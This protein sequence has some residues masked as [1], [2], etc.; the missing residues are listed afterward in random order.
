M[1]TARKLQDNKISFIDLASQ[2]QAIRP[3][4]DA[5][6]ARVLAHGQYIMGPEVLELEHKLAQFCGA[7]HA[8]TCSSGTDALLLILMAKGIKAGDAVLVPSFT[9]TAT[10]EAISLLGAT[11]IFVDILADTFNM[12]AHS[13][14]KGIVKAK[15]LGLNPKAVIAVD[16]FGQAA[17][18]DA[19][20]AI[21]KKYGLWV[22][23][24]AAQS[25]GGSYRGRKIGTIGTATATSFFPAKPLGCYGDGGAVFTDNEQL[26]AIIRSKR[27]HGTGQDKYDS[28]RIGL[29]ARFDTIQAAILLEKL[30]LFPDEIKARQNIAARYNEALASKVT[31][32]QLGA[33]VTSVWAQYT[34]VLQRGQNRESVVNFMSAQ[35][36]P[37]AVY[38]SKP[39]H[40]QIAYKTHPTATTTLP[41]CEDLSTRV[42]S[43]PMHAY[44][45]ENTQDKII[46]TFLTAIQ[47]G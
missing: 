3:Q 17:D 20:E 23:D 38:Y 45:D 22:L 18:Y 37:T 27:V 21:A 16:L 35:G 7:K 40:Q 44:L 2:Q 39:M 24:D 36:V 5:A 29:N 14:E 1:N 13:L 41:V 34:V 4:I 28:V 12:D 9:F 26:A 43:L 47:R 19:I 25:F 42:L 32:P 15:T 46:S 11:P 6:I 10:A 33:E 8:I 30:K 31:V